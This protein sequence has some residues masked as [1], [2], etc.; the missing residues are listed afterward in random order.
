M[1]E[2]VPAHLVA[3]VLED[4]Q[5]REH[6]LHVRGLEELDAAPLLERDAAGGELDL[7]VGAHVAGAEE[8]GHLAERDAL[9][10]QL[11]DAVDHEARLRLLVVGR[12]EPGLLAAGAPR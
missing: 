4:A 5:E 6:V 11:E 12:D 8:H 1:Q 9:L 10:V 7:E 2:A 3:R